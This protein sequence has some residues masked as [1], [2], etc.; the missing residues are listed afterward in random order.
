MMYQS[1]YYIGKIIMQRIWMVFISV[2]ENMPLYLMN[3]KIMNFT[4]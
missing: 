4:Y 1:R 2:L 3:Q